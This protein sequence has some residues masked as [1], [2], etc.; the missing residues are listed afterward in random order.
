MP[1]NLDD[2]ELAALVAPL[3]AEIKNT[4]WPLAP[5]TKALRSILAKLAPAAT[6]ARAI[7]AAKA[8]WRAQPPSGEEKARAALVYERKAPRGCTMTYLEQILAD[9]CDSE[10][11]GSISWFCD[12]GIDVKLGGRAERVSGGGSGPHSRRGRRMA[13]RACDQAL[14]RQPVC[15]AVRA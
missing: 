14:P 15:Q 13:S 2:P 4:R 7:P 5:R 9:L 12:A 10:I 11:K 3:S 8:D 1:L 6:T